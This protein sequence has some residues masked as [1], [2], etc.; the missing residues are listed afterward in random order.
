MDKQALRNELSSIQDEARALRNKS[1]DNIEMSISLNLIARLAQ[2][3]AQDLI[4]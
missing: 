1:G 2:I 4:K 3:I